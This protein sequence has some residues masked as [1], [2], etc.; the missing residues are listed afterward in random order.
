MIFYWVSD[1][2]AQSRRFARNARGATSIEYGLMIGIISMGLIVTV[3]ALAGEA[4]AGLFTRL[5]GNFGGSAGS[6]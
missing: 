6:S 4:L 5:A 1:L 2:A 3:Q